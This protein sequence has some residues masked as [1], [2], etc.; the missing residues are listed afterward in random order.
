MM[1]GISTEIGHSVVLSFNNQVIAATDANHFTITETKE[2][3][4]E[5]NQLSF[6]KD[7]SKYCWA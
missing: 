3:Q 5:H 1:L 7:V 4:E 2:S 6:I